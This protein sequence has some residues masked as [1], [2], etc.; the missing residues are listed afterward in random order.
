VAVAVATADE[1][2]RDALGREN[3]AGIAVDRHHGR[4]AD[5]VSIARNSDDL[6]IRRQSAER[7]SDERQAGD[8]AG[9]ANGDKGARPRP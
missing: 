9:L 4:C 2:Q 1:I 7:R 3:G 6:D 8:D 5:L